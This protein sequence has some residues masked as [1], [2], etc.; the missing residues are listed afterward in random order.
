MTHIAKARRERNAQFIVVD[1]Y[2]TPTAKS[3][4]PT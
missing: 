4:I 3:P 1:P 2:R